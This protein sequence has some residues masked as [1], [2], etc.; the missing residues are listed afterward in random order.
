M[1]EAASKAAS[2][3]TITNSGRKIASL[4]INDQY[5]DPAGYEYIG[6]DH[7]AKPTDELAREQ[8]R[9]ALHRNFQG[10]SIKAGADLFG[11]GMSAISHFGSVYAQNQ[12]ICQWTMRLFNMINFQ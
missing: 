8:K 10:Y 12:K 2:Q 3:R 1:D 6:M 11:F 9:K 5:T 4:A 7:F